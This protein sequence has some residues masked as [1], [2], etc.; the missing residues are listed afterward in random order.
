MQ[1]IEATR[2]KLCLTM[3]DLSIL[4]GL[5]RGALY[6]TMHGKGMSVKTLWRIAGALGL[7]IDLVP[8]KIDATPN[9]VV[10]GMDAVDLHPD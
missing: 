5:E 3:N 4:S 2:L 8:R 6:R 10:S 9:P 7:A 1:K